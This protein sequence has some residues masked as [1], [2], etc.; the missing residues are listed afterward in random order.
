MSPLIVILLM[1][2]VGL[3]LLVLVD[4]LKP[5]KRVPVCRYEVGE[6]YTSRHWGGRYGR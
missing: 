6:V 5:V 3:R 1:F 4:Q 2:Y